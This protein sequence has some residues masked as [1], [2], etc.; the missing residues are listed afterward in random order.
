MSEIFEKASKLKLRFN[1]NGN[2]TT[3]DL[4]DLSLEKLDK[5]AIALNKESKESKEES[6]INKPSTKS[7]EVDLKFEIVKHI[8]T[9][10]LNLEEKRKK[11]EI[12]REARNTIM[13]IIKS[14]ENEKL[15]N[16]PLEELYAQLDKLEEEKED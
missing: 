4:W 14:K 7:K 1:V 3:E 16:V 9:Y 12:T 13:D 10:K 6:F 8:I 11:A 2:I 5:L 15:S